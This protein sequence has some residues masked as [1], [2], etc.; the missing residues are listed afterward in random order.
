MSGSGR[1][2]SFDPGQPN[3]WFRR[4]SPVAVRPGEGPLTEPTVATQPWRRKSLFMPQSRPTG[5]A[6]ETG[7]VGGERT[8][9]SR[10]CGPDTGD[11]GR[12]SASPPLALP[13]YVSATPQTCPGAERAAVDQ[14][15]RTGQDLAAG[16]LS[17]ECD[18]P[19]SDPGRGTQRLR[20]TS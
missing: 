12:L 10:C 15:S 2:D 6:F 8:F 11:T 3:G 18:A 14:P 17:W 19:A 13:R 7:G 4:V 9:G 5:L 16:T 20:R 1:F